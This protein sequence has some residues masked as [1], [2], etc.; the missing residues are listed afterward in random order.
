MA[1]QNNPSARAG[2][3]EDFR[4]QYG[5]ASEGLIQLFGGF[6]GPGI[7]QQ[8]PLPAGFTSRTQFVRSIMDAP[9]SKAFLDALPQPFANVAATV[10]AARG[11]PLYPP[12]VVVEFTWRPTDRPYEDEDEDLTKEVRVENLHAL[13]EIHRVTS[14]RVSLELPSN[15]KLDF[16]GAVISM[17]MA[18]ADEEKAALQ[19]GENR[20]H[21]SDLVEA[22]EEI[23]PRTPVQ[24]LSN[25]AHRWVE[26]REAIRVER[27]KRRGQRERG[28]DAAAALPR[29]AAA[30]KPESEP[31]V[32]AGPVIPDLS[33]LTG[34]GSTP[35]MPPRASR[36]GRKASSSIISP[37][38]AVLAP[39]VPPAEEPKPTAMDEKELVASFLAD[40]PSLVAKALAAQLRGGKLSLEQVSTLAKAKGL[41]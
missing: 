6:K 41:L 4:T 17:F 8:E 33:V 5:R 10:M 29:A 1:T 13:A 12:E 7:F 30:S 31:G 27:D 24:R 28:E 21:S 11:N 16:Q 36:G 9:G 38:L 26:Q 18:L 15:G 2:E 19:L 20:K 39:A 22:L 34:G 23:Q 3:K 35:T 25:R 32:P 14:G 40:Q 37:A